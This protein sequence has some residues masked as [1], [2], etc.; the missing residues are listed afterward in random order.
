MK[1][2]KKELGFFCIGLIQQGKKKHTYFKVEDK[3]E[4]KAINS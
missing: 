4:K 2:F 3:G 1:Q